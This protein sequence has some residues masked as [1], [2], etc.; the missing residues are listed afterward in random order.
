MRYLLHI[1]MGRGLGTSGPD[2]LATPNGCWNV[3][4]H[5]L[6]MLERDSEEG[7]SELDQEDRGEAQGPWC[8]RASGSMSFSVP[9]MKPFP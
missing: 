6:A 1:V 3:V 5:R 2:S 7:D 9:L 4:S 8:C